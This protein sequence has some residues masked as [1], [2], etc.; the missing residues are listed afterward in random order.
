MRRKSGFIRPDYKWFYA[1]CAS[2]KKVKRVTG[3]ETHLSAQ[4][5]TS[6]LAFPGSSFHPH[7][8]ISDSSCTPN[9]GELL[10]QA[11]GCRPG[12]GAA[13]PIV[14]CMDSSAGNVNDGG[15]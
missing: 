10:V 15:I 13:A 1:G 4:C 5:Q 12:R 3:W 2:S 8:H 7:S 14:E 11:I 9:T 6:P